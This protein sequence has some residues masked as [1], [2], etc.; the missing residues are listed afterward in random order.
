MTLRV[1]SLI[2][3]A[4]FFTTAG[5]HGPSRQKVTKEVKI[6]APAAKVWALIAD[7]CAISSWHPAVAKCTTDGGNVAGSKRTLHIGKADGPQILEELQA[8]DPSG[9]MYRYRI[10]KT[11]IAV[12]PVSTYSSFL[13]VKDNGDKTTTVEWRSGF[14][15]A[16]AKGNPPPEL[17]DEAAVKAVSG[18]YDL[19]LAN[20]KK[21]A[22]Q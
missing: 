21:L 20:L 14:Y 11:D 3:L 12:L 9:M 17:N 1:I 5:A 4:A 13:T 7:F 10:V 22:E 16:Y 6:S 19:G 8:Y 18:V 15:R 2:I